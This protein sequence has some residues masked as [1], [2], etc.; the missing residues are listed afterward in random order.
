MKHTKLPWYVEQF[1]ED[2]IINIRA[3]TD[4]GQTS[5]IVYMDGLNEDE[6]NA[7]FIVTA[8]NEYYPMLR[9]MKALVNKLDAETWFLEIAYG[10]GI[11]VDSIKQ[12]IKQV[13][14]S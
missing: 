14:E 4:R 3:R 5:H 12:I 7:A 9:I 11:C 2:D 13:E 10:E 6:E 8:C 1:D